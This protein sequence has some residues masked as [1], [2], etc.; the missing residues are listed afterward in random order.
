MKVKG[1]FHDP[2]PH[3][4]LFSKKVE[5]FYTSADTFTQCL[6]AKYFL[7]IHLFGELIAPIVCLC[8]H[9]K[10]QHSG[11]C[12][13]TEKNMHNSQTKPQSQLKIWK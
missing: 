2:Q 4:P 7:Q 8:R 9:Y 3:P 5:I 1:P 11:L 6:F 12:N 10:Y 13:I